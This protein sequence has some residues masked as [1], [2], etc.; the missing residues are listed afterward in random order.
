MQ[1]EGINTNLSSQNAITEKR[2][3]KK[4]DSRSAIGAVSGENDRDNTKVD[5]TKNIIVCSKD[6][7][8]DERPAKPGGITPAADA[9]TDENYAVTHPKIVQQTEHDPSEGNGAAD[10]GA[11]MWW[12]STLTKGMWT[13]FRDPS[14]G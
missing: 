2:P 3:A 12:W 11:A 6:D 4:G 10:A 5:A 9:E 1:R 13:Q 8:D 7:I 14:E